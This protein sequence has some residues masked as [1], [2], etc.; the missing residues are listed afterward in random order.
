MRASVI[1]LALV[2]L[3]AA[4]PAAAQ[5]VEAIAGTFVLDEAASDPLEEIVDDGMSKL[6]R[7]Y[8]IWPISGES[9]RRLRS[10]NQP[11]AWVQ[12]VPDGGVVTVE[13]DRYKL[14]TPRDGIFED[15]EREPGDLIDVTTRLERDR[16]EQTFDAEDG[17]RVNV[18]TLADDGDRLDLEVTVTSPKLDS[19]LV[20]HLVY[21]RR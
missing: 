11:A 5:S 2:S 15:W 1:G 8:R 4:A 18:Y 7:L 21:V 16:L 12:I 9:R 19:P 10:T 17:R 13:T 20:Y 6:G 3:F 14:V